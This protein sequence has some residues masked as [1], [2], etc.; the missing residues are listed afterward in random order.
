MSWHFGTSLVFCNPSIPREQAPQPARRGDLLRSHRRNLG[1]DGLARENAERADLRARAH[2]G[3]QLLHRDQY[4]LDPPVV[5]T[6]DH[7]RDLARRDRAD[8]LYLGSA[9]RD[10]IAEWVPLPADPHR[11]VTR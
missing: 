4:L 10:G 6:G 2:R 8:R 7:H 5:G 9:D 3:A 1:Q 11:G